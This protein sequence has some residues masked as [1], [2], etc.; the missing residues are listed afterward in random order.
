MEIDFLHTDQILSGSKVSR[1]T[2]IL[3]QTQL[4]ESSKTVDDITAL[5]ARHYN[6]D[7]DELILPMKTRTIAG[8]KVVICYLA[9][10][11]YSLAGTSVAKRLGITRSAVSQ[12]VQRR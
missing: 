10:R 6:L 8:V 7:M 11:R 12:A 1:E 2:E 3:E 5:V 9:T 4:S